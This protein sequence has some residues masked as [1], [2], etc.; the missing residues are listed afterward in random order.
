MPELHR[1][2][3]DP[4]KINHRKIAARSLNTAPRAVFQSKVQNW[5]CK[6]VP[7]YGTRSS[8]EYVYKRLVARLVH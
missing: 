4:L 6:G 1:I 8:Y 2:H 3:F 5:N 7:L